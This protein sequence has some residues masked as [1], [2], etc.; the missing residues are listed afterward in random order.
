MS[1]AWMLLVGDRHE[2]LSFLYLF[3]TSFCLRV[4]KD[5]VKREWNSDRQSSISRVVNRQSAYRNCV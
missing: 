5:L 2:H 1:G 3:E 4:E